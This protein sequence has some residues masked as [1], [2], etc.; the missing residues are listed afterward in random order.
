MDVWNKREIPRPPEYTLKYS[1]E[2]IREKNFDVCLQA[3]LE[4]I[5]CGHAALNHYEVI[6]CWRREAA[7]LSATLHQEIRH[8]KDKYFR[9]LRK[10]NKTVQ[11]WDELKIDEYLS[12]LQSSTP[13]VPDWNKSV[14]VPSKQMYEYLLVR[15]FGGFRLLLCI[16]G[17]CREAAGYLVMKIRTGYFF[18]IASALLANVAR[19]R[20]LALDLA[21]QLAELYDAIYPLL[22][23]LKGTSASSLFEKKDYPSSLTTELSNYCKSLKMT[24][25]DSARK[26][27]SGTDLLAFLHILKD[28]EAAESTVLEALELAEVNPGE[29]KSEEQQEK[30]SNEK[31]EKS[32]KADDYSEA[33][34][35]LRDVSHEQNDL[36]SCDEDIG[37]CANGDP[38]SFTS[39]L[40]NYCKSKDKNYNE[41][42]ELLNDISQ[43]DEGVT[44]SKPED[45]GVPV[46]KGNEEGSEGC[47]KE[48]EDI[49]GWCEMRRKRERGRIWEEMLQNP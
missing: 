12:I 6:G 26:S 14:R 4:A 11:R 34:K 41:A 15:V 31:S 20:A 3:L 21:G 8:R 47:M 17:Y 18:N 33:M 45:L 46:N 1:A 13:K 27:K 9:I 2:E 24:N 29:V 44:L 42:L 28:D 5:L 35:L 49:D 37:V 7:I 43:E 48:K 23:N 36:P 25:D 32:A 19:I 38:L 39:K 22:D 16:E 40:K 30:S 10:V